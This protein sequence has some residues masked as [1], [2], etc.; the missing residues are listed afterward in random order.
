MRWTAHCAFGSIFRYHGGDHRL[1]LYPEDTQTVVREYLNMRY[2]LMPSII[3][4]GHE[5]SITGFPL[6]AR[7]DMLWPELSNQGSSS[8]HQYLFLRNTLVAPILNDNE[9]NGHEP[10]HQKNVTTRDVWIPPG[11]WEDAWT[12]GIVSGP[13][14]I[15]VTQ[16]FERQPMWHRRPS[17]SVL[18]DKV[19]YRVEDQDWSNLTLE[20]FPEVESTV[21][22]AVY[23][24][25][26][27]AYTKLV[28]AT[29]GEGK[30]VTLNISKTAEGS[31]R[32]WLLRLHLRSGQ[33]AKSAQVDGEEKGVVH[34]YPSDDG[35]RHVPFTGSG[36]APAH[37]AGAVAEIV[38]SVSSHERAV[39]V[40]VIEKDPV[41]LWL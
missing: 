13:Q 15:E 39:V 41:Q 5:A 37:G 18:C 19:A 4:A 33:L 6:V 20:A 16:P 28:L 35:S 7:C 26:T 29:D 38:M 34:R 21:E 10:V 11:E 3:A 8:N 31:A 24:Q 30:H 40:E 27:G 1:W 25:H 14:H 36:S 17:L 32:G 23:E 12:G 2:H 9:A 22:A